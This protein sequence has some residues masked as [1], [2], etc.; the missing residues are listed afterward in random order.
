MAKQTEDLCTLELPELAPAV[1]RGRGRPRDPYAMT[2]AE[3]QQRYR[4]KKKRI[5]RNGIIVAKYRGPNGETW[6]GRGLMPKWLSVKV[7]AGEDR[8]LYL[9]KP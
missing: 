4:D 2:N 7:L 1:R 8:A 5:K 6:S 9:V 3:R